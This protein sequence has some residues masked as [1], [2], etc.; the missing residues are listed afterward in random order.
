MLETQRL[1][2]ELW[3]EADAESF[4]ALTWD[5]G[6][7]AFPITD[8]RQPDLEAARRWIVENERHFAQTRLG[9]FALREKATGNVVGMTAIRILR[10]E[11]ENRPEITYRLRRSA[12]GRGYATEA[13]RAMLA[14]GFDSLGFEEIAASITPD[15]TDSIKVATKLGMK[16]TGR[17]ILLGL[18]AEIFRIRR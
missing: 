8:W 7:A 1:L 14:Y 18:P 16:W 17:E 4:F 15:N 2:I 10:L 6:F 5:D 3:S 12:W 11:T 9:A 13:A